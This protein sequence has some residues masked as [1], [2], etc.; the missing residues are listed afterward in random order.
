[1]KIVYGSN[2]TT[3]R[4]AEISVAAEKCGI[5]FDTARLLYARGITD[6]SAMRTFLH[7]SDKCFHDPFL[8]SGMSESVERIK[9]AVDNGESI[10]VFGDYDADGVCA[11]SITYFCLKEMG[12]NVRVTVPEREE[13]YGLNLDLVESFNAQHNIDLLITVDCGISE[14][15][16]IET[17]KSMGIDVIVTDH[18]EPPEI[19]PDCITVNPKIAGQKYSFQGLCGAGVAYKLAVALAGEKAESLIDLAAVATVADSME[20]V[21]E[22]RW[23]VK[24]GLKVLNSPNIRHT[25][26]YL[27]GENSGKKITSQTLAFQIAPRINAGG[28]MGD[29][30]TALKAFTASTDNE[31]YDYCVKLAQYNVARQ[32]ECDAIY[33]A[34]KVKIQQ[35]GISND[36]VILVADEGWKTGFIGIVAAKLVEDYSRPVI[37]FAGVNEG[38]KGS[39]RSVA[40]VNI[41]DALCA[42]KDIL[43]GFGGHS[44]AAGLTV[45]KENFTKLRK[46]LCQYVAQLD[47]PITS[48]KTAYADWNIEKRFDIDF[49]KEIELLEPFG[50]GNRKPVFTARA[51]GAVKSSPIKVG[52]LHYSFSLPVGD[53]LDFDGAEDAAT[54]ALPAPK[55]ILFELSYSVFNGRESVKGIVR[56][57]LPKFSDFSSL[58]P[59]IV[60]AELKKTAVNSAV[61]KQAITVANIPFEQGFGSLYVI[62]DPENLKHVDN[63]GSAEVYLF[64]LPNRTAHNCIL[65]SP[66]QIPTDYSRV[67]FADQPLAYP[68][69]PPAE[70]QAV[71]TGM[72]FVNAL[73]V[74][75]ADFAMAY[76]A[77]L[78]ICGR[79]YVGSCEAYAAY[80]PDVPQLQFIFSAEVFMELGIFGI[81][82]GKLVLN[83]EV[84]NSL[85][86]SRIYAAVKEAKV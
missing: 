44:Q 23:I 68:L 75:R 67:I 15:Q 21:D 70:R 57:V 64:N 14:A 39:A 51:D 86:N 10:L 43:E 60:R 45:S 7:P 83:A 72:S 22:N 12:A 9:R 82:N 80:K 25:I 32:V 35:E 19:L 38:Y 61:T 37:V 36:R 69:L 65:I 48:Q 85:D 26:K 66:V 76:S 18:H 62:S 84:K 73:S 41:F 16:N 52:S 3:E 1:M 47:L 33:T 78:G 17:I 74:D 29:A 30:A 59:F 77:M 54:L 5:T 71:P 2:L 42:A 31:V 13:G 55:T 27:L 63:S 53:M 56:N 46:A 81:K 40:D 34:A 58:M 49:A 28:R 20:L 8:L 24:K 4:A 79:E 6:V 50:L 11:A